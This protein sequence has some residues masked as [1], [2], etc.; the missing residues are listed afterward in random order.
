MT[1]IGKESK[2]YMAK[3]ESYVLLAKNGFN[4]VFG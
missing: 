1:T 2:N 3:F 4:N